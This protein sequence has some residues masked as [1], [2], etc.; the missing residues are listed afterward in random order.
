MMTILMAL[1]LCAT[2]IGAEVETNENGSV[3]I[4]RPTG[5]ERV[6]IVP[7]A[8]PGIEH[9][10]VVHPDAIREA[11]ARVAELEPYVEATQKLT[12]EIATCDEEREADAQAYGNTAHDLTVCK[13]S[14]KE[15]RREKWRAF[16]MGGTGGAAA[17]TIVFILI[18]L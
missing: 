2:S 9:H 7:T 18:L 6:T 14:L 8:I 3:I 15:C 10:W 13:A 4:V 16:F 1:L 17:A 11:N 12:E 5:D